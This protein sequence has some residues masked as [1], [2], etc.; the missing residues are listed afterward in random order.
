MK[1]SQTWLIKNYES[2]SPVVYLCPAKKP[3]IGYG[4]V[5]LPGETFTRITEEQADQLLRK[6]VG[7]AENC[8]NNYVKVTLSQ[9]QFDALASLIFNIGINAFINSTMLKELNL[10]K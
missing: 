9:N 10:A 7:I 4:H 1:V 2:F 6:D 5:V 3:T 8:I